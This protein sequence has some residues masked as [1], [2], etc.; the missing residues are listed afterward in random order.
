[1]FWNRIYIYSLHI[2][3]YQVQ[4]YRYIY[5]YI[6]I[7]IMVYIPQTA[8]ISLLTAVKTDSREFDL[9][10]RN[11][12]DRAR[13]ERQKKSLTLQ[14]DL[15]NVFW[16]SAKPQTA[17]TWSSVKASNYIDVKSICVG[18]KKQVVRPRNIYI[19]IC[20]YIYQ[21]YMYIYSMHAKK[22]YIYIYIFGIYRNIYI[23]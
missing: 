16:S 7:H 15:T 1:M 8:L 12:Q 4:Q 6:Y 5:T 3:I 2:Y 13:R 14:F 19:N 11:L 17:S 21:E 18:D 23:F 10:E 20:I 9:T 22:L